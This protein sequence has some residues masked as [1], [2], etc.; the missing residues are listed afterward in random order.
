MADVFISHASSELELAS[1]LRRHLETEGLSVYV[2]ELDVQPG[3]KWMPTI[4]QMLKS[5]QWI[6]CLASKRA[7]ASPWVMQEM[8][9]AIGTNKKL[10]PIVWDM[11]RS[12]LPAWMQQYQAVDLGANH[13]SSRDAIS[14]IAETIRADK[15]KGWLIL[16][17]M[18]AGLMMLGGK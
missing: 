1:F 12:Q 3:Q 11:S 7:C 2:A 8:G 14:L 13:E 16:S 4:V 17:L 18:A 5:S 15:Q 6:L 10:I 9:I